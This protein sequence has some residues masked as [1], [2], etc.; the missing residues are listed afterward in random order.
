ML[1]I[2]KLY[3]YIYIGLKKLYMY[4]YIGLIYI[5]NPCGTYKYI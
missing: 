1:Y 3:M 2:Y 5:Y 4:I